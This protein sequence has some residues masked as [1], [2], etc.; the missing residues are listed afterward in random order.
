M[1]LNLNVHCYHIAY[2]TRKRIEEDEFKLL[3]DY[4]KYTQNNEI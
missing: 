3:E 4:E 2:R 1:N